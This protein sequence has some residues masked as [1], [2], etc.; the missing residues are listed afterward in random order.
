MKVSKN[1]NLGYFINESHIEKAF[2]LLKHQLSQETFTFKTLDF[3]IFRNEHYIRT[4]DI[5]KYYQKFLCKDLFYNYKS[6]FYNNEYLLPKGAY[7]LRRFNFTSFN[8]FILYYSLGYYFYELLSETL[9][10]VEKSKSNKNKAFTYYGGK[11]NFDSPKNSEIYYQ[12]D[13]SSFNLGIKRKIK[14]GL[15]DKKKICIIKLDIQ[16]YFKTIDNKILIDVIDKYSLPS[17]KKTLRFDNAT[18]NSILDLFKYFNG[19]HFG[20]PLSSQNIFSNFLSYIYLFELDNYIQKLDISKEEGFSYFR[21]VDDFFLIFEKE[22]KEKN[23]IIGDLFFDISTKITDFLSEK[24]NLK[25]NHLKSQKWILNSNTDLQKFISEEKFISFSKYNNED[26]KSLDDKVKDISD[27]I[28][29]LKSEYKKNGIT[30]IS[31]ENDLTLKEVFDKSVK[32]FIRSKQSQTK[33]N[34]AFKDWNPILTLNSTKA[35]IY[36]I[37]NSKTGYKIIEE[38]FKDNFKQKIKKTQYIYLLEKFV[39]LENYDKSFNEI[40]LKNE[41]GFY[42]SL[43]KR[44]IEGKKDREKKYLNIEDKVLLKNDSLMQQIKMLI[45]SEKEERYNVAFNHLLNTFHLYCFIKDKSKSQTQLKN[46]NQLNIIDFLIKCETPIQDINFVMSF[47]DRRNK[48]NISHPG[49]KLMENW[50]VGK[51]EYLMY[52]KSMNKLISRNLK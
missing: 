52:L 40:I 46:Y 51:K 29:N 9:A 39:N 21:Y 20:L 43:I 22:K 3:E 38:F 47:F 44:M 10:S 15:D 26:K 36:L 4:F 31:N 34:R 35:L 33:I 14:K 12:N 37:D 24:L 28:E 18:K 42:Y 30:K 1:F 32:N 19:N 16:D 41:G 13:Y 48:N 50:V 5:K 49:D 2:E 45:L 6:I 17:I 27:I 7:G 23:E 11:I 8:L 25:I